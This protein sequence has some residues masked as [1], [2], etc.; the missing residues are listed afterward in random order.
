MNTFFNCFVGEEER[1]ELSTLEQFDEYEEWHLKCSHY[2]LLCS[3][4]GQCIALAKNFNFV[5]AN[6]QLFNP[7]YGKLR[8][9]ALQMTQNSNILMR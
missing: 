1:E 6:S 5:S 4:K 3:F 7:V 2:I 8:M 9:D